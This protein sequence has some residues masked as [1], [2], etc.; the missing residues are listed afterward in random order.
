[1]PAALTPSDRFPALAVSCAIPA[2]TGLV[3]STDSQLMAS[4]PAGGR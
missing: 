3:R 4:D 2:A 1:M